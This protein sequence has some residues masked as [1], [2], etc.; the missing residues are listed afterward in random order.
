MITDYGLTGDFQSRT[1]RLRVKGIPIRVAEVPPM[2]DGERRQLA[3]AYRKLPEY[4][5]IYDPACMQLHAA[6]CSGSGSVRIEIEAA[7]EIRTF[8][9]SPSRR[10]TAPVAEG[11]ILRF[12][13]GDAEPRYFVVRINGLPPLMLAIDSPEADVPVPSGPGVVDGGAFLSDP[14]GASDQTAD[15]QRALAAASVA[16]GTLVV[17]PGVFSVT[18]LCLRQAAGVRIHLSPGCLI[19]VR[20]SAPGANEHRHGLWIRDCS[21]ISVTGRGCI[22]HQAYEHYVLAGNNYQDGMVDYYTANDACPWTTQSPLFITGSRR[23]RVEGITIRNGRNF[24][25]NCRGCDDVVIRGV[26]ILT[27]AA[28]TPEY[29]DGINTGSCRGV[30]VENCLVAANDDSFASGHYLGSH[31][32]R[33][34]ANHVVR[35]LLGWNLRGSGAR[36]GFF[37]GFDQGDFTFERCD[38]LAMTHSTLLVHALRPGPS[39]APSRYGTIRVADCTFDARRVQFLFS[40]EKAAVDAV[41]L[42][43]VSFTGSPPAG[44]VFAVEGDPV[45]PI[46]SLTLRSV[47]CDGRPVMNLAELNP[48]IAEVA[49]VVVD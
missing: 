38:F 18:G 24:N 36:L 3:A 17:P 15:F 8:E 34:S 42:E 39:G 32:R 48:R 2:D 45:S 12:E 35:G 23:I 19:K 41:E 46:G 22:D 31:D 33:A 4:C 20:P 6:H 10:G 43:R 28:C 11:R 40:V 27:P 21:D 25:I 30:L 37:A 1:F 5:H 44:A 7:E 13:T 26:R 9:V 29:A 47:T 16:A 49:R 14:T